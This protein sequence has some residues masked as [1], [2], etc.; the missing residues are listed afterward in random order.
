MWQRE[1]ALIMATSSVQIWLMASKLHVVSPVSLQRGTA[2]SRF[3]F[4]F[5]R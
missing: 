3:R 4:V 1:R 5:E 2:H